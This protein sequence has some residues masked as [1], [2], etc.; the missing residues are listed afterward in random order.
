LPVVL[1]QYPG[2]IHA[3]LAAVMPYCMSMEVIDPVPTEGVFT[4]DVHIED[5]WAIAGDQPGNG[6]VIDHE[7]L[8]RNQ[9]HGEA[10]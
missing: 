6:L 7:A 5:G 3:H 10:A 8:D 4:T 9:W 1:S 2:N